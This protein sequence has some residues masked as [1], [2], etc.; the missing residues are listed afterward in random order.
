MPKGI[1]LQCNIL[2][3]K[4]GIE[5]LFPK[6]YLYVNQTDKFLLAARKRPKNMT[7]NYMISLDHDCFDKNSK[8]EVGKV[9]SNF[10]GTIF[11]VF[12]CGKNPKDTKIVEEIRNQLAVVT[13]VNNITYN[14]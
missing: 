4:D 10:M 7:A 14:Y 5:K 2:R 12:D 13:Y 8:F 1:T 3:K 9:R 11:Q 6:F